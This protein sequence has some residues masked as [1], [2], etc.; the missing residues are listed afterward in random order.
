M[1]ER[2]LTLG[3]LPTDQ[4]VIDASSVARAVGQG[5]K[6]RRTK[7]KEDSVEAPD[8]T[9]TEDWIDKPMIAGQIANQQ[10]AKPNGIEVKVLELSKADDLLEYGRVL[11]AGSGQSASL[12][13]VDHDKQY[14]ATLQT[15]QVLLTIEKYLFKKVI[16]TR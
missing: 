2:I 15:W 8:Y 16:K 9:E 4:Y 11:Q 7:Q 10:L 12:R 13:I 14:N 1:T 5:V 3:Q 6:R